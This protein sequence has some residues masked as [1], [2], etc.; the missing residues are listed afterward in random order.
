MHIFFCNKK[1]VDIKQLWNQPQV[2]LIV[3]GYPLS[4]GSYVQ[5]VHMPKKKNI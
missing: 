1:H 4:Q 3:R 5:V 2:N